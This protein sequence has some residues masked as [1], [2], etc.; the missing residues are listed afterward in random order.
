M[1]CYYQEQEI[2]YKL[3]KKNEISLYDDDMPNS[4]HSRQHCS[5]GHGLCDA[6]IYMLTEC[7][8]LNDY[9]AS[10]FLM[11]LV[12]LNLFHLYIHEKF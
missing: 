2:L 11:I 12:S 8:K 7:G 3:G 10:G 4:C 9:F 1:W 5:S 6:G